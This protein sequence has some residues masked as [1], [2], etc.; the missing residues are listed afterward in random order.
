MKSL[1]LEKPHAIVMVG[2]PGSGK[3]F[4]AE[5]FAQTFN[6]PYLDQETIEKFISD[7]NGVND[8]IIRLLNEFTKTQASLVLEIFTDSR[9]SR[10]ELAKALKSAGYVTVFVW[11]QV[12]EATART[13]SIK[14]GMSG[15]IEH[16]ERVRVF[17]PPHESEAAV[18]ISGKHTYASQVK[19]VLKRLTASRAAASSSSRP[20]M[21]PPRNQIVLR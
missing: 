15:D 16:A 8:I 7:E 17:S 4:F 18:V 10:T 21:P 20:Q 1:S 19:I 13:R 5:K 9:T 3:T 12:D 6:A 11:V 14:K 2:I